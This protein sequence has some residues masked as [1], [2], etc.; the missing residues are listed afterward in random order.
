VL[1]LTATMRRG[2]PFKQSFG[3]TGTDLP[4]CDSVVRSGKLRVDHSK[5]ELFFKWVKI[6]VSVKKRMALRQAEGRDQAVDGFADRLA[7]GSKGAVVPRRSDSEGLSSSVEHLEFQQL[8]AYPREHLVCADSLQN[9]AQNKIGQTQALPIQLSVEPIR[10]RIGGSSQ[11]ID[12]H[13][14]IYNRHARKLLPYPT[15]TRPVQVSFPLHLAAKLADCGLSV[16][17]HQQLQGSFY[18]RPLGRGAAAAHRPLD[19]LIVN[20]DIRPHTGLHV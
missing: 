18:H 15:E 14:R 13:R 4:S 7:T 3:L 17:F 1:D 10:M 19:Q 11:V 2:V 20:F 8:T 9:L 6:T 16:R 5:T 12:P